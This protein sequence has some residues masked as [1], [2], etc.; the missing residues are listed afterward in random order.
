MTKMI[1]A[2]CVDSMVMADGVVVAE[3]EILSEGV[4][5]SEGVII[6]DEDRVTYLT[7]N[8]ADIKQLIEMASSI[9]N[10]ASD[11]MASIVDD[12]IFI[13]GTGGASLIFPPG[14]AAGK[15]ALDASIEEFDAL[16]ETLK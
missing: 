8:A 4:G 1:E 7:S 5:A 3:A 11:L 6:L 10:D 2:M 12:T 15:A 16:K 9:L 13:P 14:F